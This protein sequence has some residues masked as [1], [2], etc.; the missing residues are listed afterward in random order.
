MSQPWNNCEGKRA[1]DETRC[2]PGSPRNK[3]RPT[4][5]CEGLIRRGR[6]PASLQ[7]HGLSE[8]GW[9]HLSMFLGNHTTLQSK[10][11]FPSSGSWSWSC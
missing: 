4:S 6:V 9:L 8:V 2:K 3:G 7:V 5:V 1:G 10:S 11:S